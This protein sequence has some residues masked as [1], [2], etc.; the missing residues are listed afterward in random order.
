MRVL[1]AA[2]V[3]V[4]MAV[5]AL[6]Q[7]AGDQIQSVIQSQINA[8]QSDD[9]ETAFTFASPMIQGIFGSSERFGQMV[10]QGYPMVWRPAGVEYTAL[11]ER[12]GVLYQNVLITDQAGQLH[13]L[14]YE[15]IQ[16]SDGWEINGVQF[17]RPGA[18]GA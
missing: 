1:L 9:F 4:F 6:A 5:Q 16:T 12:G 15:M 18:L 10:R 8:F 2:I 14:E 17:K 3:S 11:T 13:L 7:S